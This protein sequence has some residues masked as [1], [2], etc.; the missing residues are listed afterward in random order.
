MNPNDEEKVLDAVRNAAS[1]LALSAAARDRIE[2]R[3]RGGA[4]GATTLR[5]ANGSWPKRAAWIVPAAAVM[6]L[7]AIWILP[8]IDRETSVSAA[9]VLGRSQQALSSPQ[10]GIE[11]LTYDLTLGGVL[12]DLLPLGQ[13]GT[14]TVEETVDYGHPGRYRLVK[15]APGGQV[16]AGIADDPLTRARVRYLRVE[17]GGVMVRF[18]DSN[19]ATLSVVEIKRSLLRAVIGMMQA[20]EDKS[21][22]EISRGGEPA[23]AVDVTG[24]VE[25][26]GLVTLRRASAVVDRATADLLDFSAEGTIGGQ[27]FAIAFNLRS[28]E[29]PAAASLPADAFTIARSADDTI[30][31]LEPGSSESL[32]SA[33]ARCLHQ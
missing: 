4:S 33:I 15:L 30:V 7:A 25:A 14:F 12:K 3:L 24:T 19:I 23:Y 11:V 32:L 26:G 18:G 17:G 2:H 28:R 13:A 9:E 21:L 5:P 22:Q 31:D 8:A 27:A 1:G 6:V 20:T 10:S 16:M 29:T